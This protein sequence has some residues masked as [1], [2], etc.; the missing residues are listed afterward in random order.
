MAAISQPLRSSFLIGAEIGLL[1]NKI[2]FLWYQGKNPNRYSQATG[3][4]IYLHTESISSVPIAPTQRNCVCERRIDYGKRFC[5]KKRKEMVLP[6]LCGGRKWQLGTERVY[7]YGKQV[8][9]RKAV[10]AGNGGLRGKE[11]YCKGW[12]HHAW[13][14]A[15]YLGRGYV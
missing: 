5:K 6:L 14:T 13:G 10:K 12:Q 1:R 9:N 7:R 15:R 4:M 3:V 11:I 8:R 2:F